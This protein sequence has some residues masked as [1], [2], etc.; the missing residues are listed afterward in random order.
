MLH[1]FRS[2]G[3]F[4]TMKTNEISAAVVDAALH[5]HRQLGPGL[6][7]SVYE[8]VLAHELQRRGVSCERQRPV[9]IIYDGLEFPDPFR[10]DLF[11]AGRVFVELKSVAKLEPVHFRQLLTYL[12]LGRVHVGL[13][14]NFNVPLLKDGLHRLVDGPPEA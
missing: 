11:V 14:I 13:L 2:S 3:A 6:L 8:T 10:V 4:T 7:E 9:P 1:Q 12:R 5:I